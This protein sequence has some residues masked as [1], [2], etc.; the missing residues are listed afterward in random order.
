MKN[1]DI[2]FDI[3]GCVVNLMQQLSRYLSA[4]AGAKII[5]HNQFNFF[6]SPAISKKELWQYI[7]NCYEDYKNTPVYP[8]AKELF[9]NLYYLVRKPITFVTSRPVNAA[10]QTYKLMDTICIPPY[11][12]SFAKAPYHKRDF[13]HGF[14]YYMEDRRKTAFELANTGKIKIFIPQYSYNKIDVHKNII[15]ISGIEDLNNIIY[16]LVS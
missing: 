13:L 12:I 8:G 2:A 10:T 14:K 1:I 3:D 6:T 7:Y 5:D 4:Y 9:H 11:T 15:R 16:D